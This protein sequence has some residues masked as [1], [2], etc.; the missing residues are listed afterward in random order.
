MISEINKIFKK[1]DIYKSKFVYIYSD[2]RAIF[3]IE[4]KKPIIFVNKFLDLFLK[5]NITCIVPTFSYN[6]E[7]N[8]Y[9]ESTKSKVGFLGNYILKEKKHIRSQHP[10]FSFIAIGKNANILKKISKSAFSKNSVHGKLYKKNC[11]FL[12]LCRPL[13]QGNTLVHHIEHLN[14]AKYRFNKVFKTK[15]FKNKKLVG[16]NYSAFLRKDLNDKRSIF[17]FA[18]TLKKLKN[19]KYFFK[20]KFFNSEILIYKYDDFYDDLNFLYKQNKKIFLKYR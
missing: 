17:S 20:H 8:F 14:N 12:N 9:L 1:S 19:K 6:I 13:I 16:S 7:K 18:K 2:F 10:L 5:K 15:L 11:Y 4:K 3:E